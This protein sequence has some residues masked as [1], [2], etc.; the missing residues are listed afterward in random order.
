MDIL[1]KLIEGLVFSNKKMWEESPMFAIDFLLRATQSVP[2]TTQSELHKMKRELVEA[3]SGGFIEYW[4]VE[5][6]QQDSI[7]RLLNNVLNGLDVRY[8]D[9]VYTIPEKR[10]LLES[11]EKF[12][13][14]FKREGAKAHVDGFLR[15]VVVP[16]LTVSLDYRRR[17]D[18]LTK[19]LLADS[20]DLNEVTERQ[21]KFCE[22]ILERLRSEFPELDQTDIPQSSVLQTAKVFDETEDATLLSREDVVREVGK[23]L[24]NLS[25]NE[26]IES[27]LRQFEDA[28]EEMRGGKNA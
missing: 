13:S 11:A 28:I 25:E 14:L 18:S 2:E 26:E 6:T 8:D 16:V 10:S 1:E 17:L 3:Q 7:Y 24:I 23:L 12:M 9:T 5:R 22:V 20:F 21:L 27:S 4:A 19:S 15:N